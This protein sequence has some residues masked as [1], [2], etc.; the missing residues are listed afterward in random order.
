MKVEAIS[1]FG[2]KGPAAFLL[3]LGGRRVLLDC[4]EGPDAKRRPDLAGVGPFDAAIV[5]H[6]HLDHIGAL[7]L[8]APEGVPIFMTALVRE[9]AGDMPA[10][11]AGELPVMGSTDI[12]G[13][14]V[15]TGRNGHAPGGVWLHLEDRR[16]GESLVYTG[17][18]SRES[19]LYPFDMPPPATLAVVDAS[20]GAY[21][22][23]LGVGAARLVALAGE[24]PLLLPAPADGRGLEMAV[25]LAQAGARVRLCPAHRR[26]AEIVLA[27]DAGTLTAAG[28]AALAAMLASAGP[29]DRDAAPDGVMVAAKPGLG[30]GL[31]RDLALKWRDDPSVQIVLT[32]HIGE[33]TLAADFVAEGRAAFVR[34]NVH[35]P[36]SDLRKIV[37]SIGANAVMPAFLDHAKLPALGA[38][39]GSA[40][41][42][43][44]GTMQHSGPS[45]PT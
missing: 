4:G 41:L 28:R 17:D 27:A 14:R 11:A 37:A 38:A 18:V 1:G 39:L 40:H 6:G 42:S 16:S 45:N 22:E 7:D 12:A 3:E 36:V 43:M 21:D 35:P 31:A 2:V 25:V 19:A 29:L 44:S 30:S 20:Y 13:L 15:T 26:V 9:L 24:G 10:G 32:G 8:I 34:W 33:G 23:P 5:S